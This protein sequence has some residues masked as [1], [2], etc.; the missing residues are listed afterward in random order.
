MDYII[1]E[2][3]SNGSLKYIKLTGGCVFSLVKQNLL[4]NYTDEETVDKLLSLGDLDYLGTTPVGKST[5]W[6]DKEHCRAQMR[7]LNNRAH[8]YKLKSIENRDKL[9]RLMKLVFVFKDKGW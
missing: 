5:H 4:E 8:M 1:A 6:N 3:L 9:A 7:D 2:E